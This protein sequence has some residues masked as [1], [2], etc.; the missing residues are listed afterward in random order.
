MYYSL[1]ADLNS[2]Y[3]CTNCHFITEVLCKLFN[4][5]YLE[6]NNYY[7]LAEA[8]QYRATGPV[9]AADEHQS[10]SVSWLTFSSTLVYVFT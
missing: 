10:D 1:P 7:Y 3:L 5:Y 8:T 9:A 6:H 4:A 2:N